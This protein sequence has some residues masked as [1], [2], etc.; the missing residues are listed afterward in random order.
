MTLPRLPLVKAQRSLLSGIRLSREL[1]G[2]KGTSLQAEEALGPISIP[3]RSREVDPFQRTS[4]SR[5]EKPCAYS[6]P[7]QPL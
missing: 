6:T 2:P 1:H 3:W 7:A 5:A 4:A